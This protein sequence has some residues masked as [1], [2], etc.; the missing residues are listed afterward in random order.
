MLNMRNQA[1]RL[2]VAATVKGVAD[3]V[4]RNGVMTALRSDPSS[5]QRGEV[6]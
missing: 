3:A 4:N 2:N 6:S 1:N 5:R